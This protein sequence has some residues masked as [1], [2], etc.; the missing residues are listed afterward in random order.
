MLAAVL[1]RFVRGDGYFSMSASPDG[2]DWW[3][4]DEFDADDP[5]HD[6]V[7]YCTLDKGI[8]ITA[9]ERA[10]IVHAVTEEVPSGACAPPSPS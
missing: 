8:L 9:E 5:Q 1:R 7:F 2:G 3:D 4:D 6:R 10:A